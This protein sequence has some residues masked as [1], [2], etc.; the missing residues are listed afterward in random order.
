MH[1][2]LT[3]LGS[4]SLSLAPRNPRAFSSSSSRP[5]VDVDSRYARATSRGSN[6]LSLSL[7]L[8][9]LEVRGFEGCARDRV[10]WKEGEARCPFF[11]PSV[12]RFPLLIDDRA[13]FQRGEKYHCSLDFS[14]DRRKNTK[15]SLESSVSA[16][17][18]SSF[19]R[20]SA[21]CLN[22]K[23]TTY[24]TAVCA[25]DR[26]PQG[27]FSLSLTLSGGE[28]IKRDRGGDAEMFAEPSA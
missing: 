12:S 6:H 2:H 1:T 8:G 21:H 13:R 20:V 27:L 25:V 15:E 7:C 28:K 23:W 22:T 11:Y 26:S 16:V 24:V 14:E 4:L 5:L 10:S 17:N 19:P 18:V 3:P 9:G